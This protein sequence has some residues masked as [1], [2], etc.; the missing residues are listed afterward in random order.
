[1]IEINRKQIDSMPAMQGFSPNALQQSIFDTMVKSQE[2]YRYDDPIQLIME[3]KLR[4]SIVTAAR[5]L[6]RS[7][8][9]FEVFRDSRAN[10]EFW[11]R[12]DSGGFE[13]K[14]NVRPS[15]AIRD[16]YKSGRLY[17]TECSTAMF[18]VWYKAVLDVLP[19][20]QFNKL[21]SK[22]F[23]MNWL[24][25]DRNLA[26]VEKSKPVDELPGDARYFMNPDV[27]P[28]TPEWQGENV[29]YLG[30]GQYYGHGIGIE[31]ARNMIRILN[32]Q[33]REGAAAS[34]YLMDSA[35]RQDYAYLARYL[36]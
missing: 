9:D 26:I 36:R 16:I 28:M 12:T 3:L 30:N 6:H 19:E 24:H 5:D 25:I 20:E 18:I 13:L 23:L 17:G 7:G 32:G 29:F 10:P 15:D 33:R 34:A 22:I 1:M 8:M 31:D 11:N 14:E 35:K 2:T 4:N 21:Y 27:D